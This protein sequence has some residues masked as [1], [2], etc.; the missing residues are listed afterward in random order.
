[1]LIHL[2]FGVEKNIQERRKA[3][4]ITFSLLMINIQ[5]D[6]YKMGEL[7]MTGK[8]YREDVGSLEFLCTRIQY[9]F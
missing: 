7:E 1:M 2:R 8:V 5:V 3:R 6:D 9:L 4:S